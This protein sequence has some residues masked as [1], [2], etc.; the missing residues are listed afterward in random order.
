[1]PRRQVQQQKTA[2]AAEFDCWKEK[3]S[4]M[5]K[6]IETTISDNRDA[7]KLLHR[8]QSILSNK[9]A[10]VIGKNYC[11][12]YDDN[13]PDEPCINRNNCKNGKDQQHIGN[14]ELI[15]TYNACKMQLHIYKLLNRE[16]QEGRIIHNEAA[17]TKNN[18]NKIKAAAPSSSSRLSKSLL[19]DDDDDAST[20]HDR[21]SSGSSSSSSSNNKFHHHHRSS[22]LQDA[23]NSI[24]DSEQVAREITEDLHRQR[25]TLEQ[26]HGR[27]QKFSSMTEH[28]NGLLKSMNK[29]WWQKW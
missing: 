2:T 7:S 5:I 27:L 25:E 11:L 17:R 29:P 14:Q 9:M 3:L 19:F 26:T 21:S 20:K 22:R 4:S 10:P 8:A 16:K 13:S 6:D 23:L 15:D 18:E 24:N 12:V 28:A 1:M